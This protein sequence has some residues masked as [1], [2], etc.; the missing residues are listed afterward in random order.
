[1]SVGPYTVTATLFDPGNNDIVGNAF[2]RFRLRNYDGTVPTVQSAGLFIETQLDSFPATGGAI[3]QTLWGNNVITPSGTYWTCE[4]WNNGRITSSGNYLIDG[5]TNLNTATPLNPSPAPGPPNVIVFE[6]NGAM[7]S[8]Q[9]TLNLESTDSSVVITDEGNGTLNL[10]SKGT[11][12]NVSG[13]GGFWG[14]GLAMLSAIYQVPTLGGVTV[15]TT[16]DQISVFEFQLLAPFTIGSVSAY[17]VTGASSGSVNFGIYSIAGAKLI[18]S[19]ALTATSSGS[20]QTTTLGTAVTLPA[21]SYYFAQSSHVTGVQIAGYSLGNAHME[22]LINA[23]GSVK[24]GQAANA[25]VGGVMPSTL[26][27]VSADS[28]GGVSMAGAFFGC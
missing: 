26:G 2:V 5:N 12:F 18:D 15:S 19:G 27:A 25:T 4:F 20:A 22:A 14:A 9:T 23:I 16:I 28:L 17:V 11:A 21:G 3:S 8:S 6:N 13:V 1:M 24:V 10:V 7:N